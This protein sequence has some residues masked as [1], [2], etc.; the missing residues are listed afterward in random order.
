MEVVSGDQEFE[1][2]ISKEII[3]VGVD[4]GASFIVGV[5]GHV[6]SLF[7]EFIVHVD[8]VDGDDG[9]RVSDFVVGEIDHEKSTGQLGDDQHVVVGHWGVA[10]MRVSDEDSLIGWP[11]IS[12]C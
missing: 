6:D 1:F 8:V 4:E 7:V 12:C 10:K 11:A 2:P 5:V 3:V 9:N